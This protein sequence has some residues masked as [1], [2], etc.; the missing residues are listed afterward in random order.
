[1]YIHCVS[2]EGK[3]AESRLCRI[4]ERIHHWVSVSFCHTY[5]LMKHCTCSVTMGGGA[6]KHILNSHSVM[7]KSFIAK[8]L[9]QYTALMYT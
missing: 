2:E 6:D 7:C 8:T 9:F 5:D 1:M 3:Q 4:N